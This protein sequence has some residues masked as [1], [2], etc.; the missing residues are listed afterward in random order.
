[1]YGTEIEHG[2]QDTPQQRIWEA[3]EG[4]HDSHRDAQADIH[5]SEVEQIERNVRFDLPRYVD[6]TLLVSERGDHVDKFAQ[7][8]VTR[9]QQEIDQYDRGE[10]RSDRVGRGRQQ[11]VPNAGPARRTS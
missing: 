3:Q 7:E 1:M 6:G 4:R 2:H 9:H 5:Q 11:E 10:G 8:D